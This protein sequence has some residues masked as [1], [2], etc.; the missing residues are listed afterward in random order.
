MIDRTQTRHSLR[1]NFPV[2]ARFRY[3]FEKLGEFSGIIFSPWT[4]TNC[5]FVVLSVLG[6]IVLRW[7]QILRLR[8]APPE[9]SNDPVLSCL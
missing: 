6:F 9:T 5:I 4:E 1:R 8:L 7:V 2:L 3:V